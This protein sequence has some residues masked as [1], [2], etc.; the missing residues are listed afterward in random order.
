MNKKKPRSN[1]IDQTAW[2]LKYNSTEFDFDAYLWKHKNANED[3]AYVIGWKFPEAKKSEIKEGQ[4]IFVWRASYNSKIKDSGIIAYGKILHIEEDIKK[5]YDKYPD[6]LPCSS[7]CL[8]QG[9]SKKDDIY[10]KRR[11][12]QPLFLEKSHTGNVSATYRTSTDPLIGIILELNCYFDFR[13]P[14]RTITI[15]PLSIEEQKALGISSKNK[16]NKI[17]TQEHDRLYEL[18][19][20]EIPKINP[21]SDLESKFENKQMPNNLPTNSNSAG[22]TPEKQIQLSSTTTFLLSTFSY[23]TPT[24][25]LPCTLEKPLAE[26]KQDSIPV[27]ENKEEKIKSSQRISEK[28]MTID[29]QQ[30]STSSSSIPS[31]SINKTK[32]FNPGVPHSD[33]Q[34]Y[35]KIKFHS[36]QARLQKESNKKRRKSDAKNTDISK[37][38]P[39]TENAAI[40]EGLSFSEDAL[41][42]IGHY[43][44]KY[45]YEKLKAHYLKKYSPA[46]IIK[47][48]DKGCT[49]ISEPND[50]EVILRWYDKP[51]KRVR[52]PIDIKL[53]KRK[54]SNHFVLKRRYIEIKTTTS[55]SGYIA[56]ITEN[57]FEKMR[58]HRKKYTLFR[59]SNVEK[60]RK[61]ED[62][63]V[64][65][66]K[67]PLQKIIDGKLPIHKIKLKI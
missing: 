39:L 35:S 26:A 15:L 24:L 18:W 17:H 9:T 55:A 49:L 34:D 3:T 7:L 11:K 28:P 45:I 40:S 48:N 1:N 21:R 67:D 53:T 8:M 14:N 4:K 12:L 66:I 6:L 42:A 61:I 59:V 52:N 63:Y 56:H 33:L 22:S 31:F 47:D 57:E 54:R 25:S 32:E 44:E 38:P 58:K 43:G 29:D 16:E 36:F 20:K 10:Q 19:K 65:K 23:T 51:N 37:E 30:T 46:K 50:R 13:T 62:I 5:A 2:I 60:A 41:F 27:I 64:E